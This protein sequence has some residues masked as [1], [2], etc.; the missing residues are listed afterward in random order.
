MAKDNHIMIGLTTK[1]KIQQIDRKINK[2]FK[3]AMMRAK[4][5]SKR[6][7][8]KKKQIKK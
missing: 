2:E 5:K 6:K 8:D 7:T 3:T 1:A 4:I